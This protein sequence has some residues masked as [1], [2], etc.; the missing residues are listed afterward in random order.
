MPKETAEYQPHLKKKSNFSEDCARVFPT[1]YSMADFMM[2]KKPVR[3]AITN[4]KALDEYQDQ[5]KALDKW[6]A[7]MYY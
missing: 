5:D 6:I 3:T 7:R 4:N 1:A 2:E